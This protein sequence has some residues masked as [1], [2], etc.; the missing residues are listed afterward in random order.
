MIDLRGYTFDEAKDVLNQMHLGIQP[1]GEE[2]SEEYPEGQI[3]SQSEEK[4]TMVEKNTTILVVISSGPGE[5]DVPDVKG[6]AKGDAETTLRNAGLVPVFD[7]ESSDSIPNDQVISQSPEAG[8]KAKKGDTVTVML[9]KGRETVRMPD[10][11]NKPEAEAREE[12]KNLG[13]TVASTSSDYSDEIPE[14]NVMG[15]SIAPDKMVEQ[16]TQVTLT[17]SLGRK[18]TTQYYSL[19]N[20]NIDLPRSIPEDAIRVE[21]KSP[22]INQKEM[23]PSIPGLQPPSP[24]Q[25]MRPILKTAARDI[26]SL[27]GNGLIGTRMTQRLQK[28]IRLPL[29]ALD[30]RRINTGSIRC[31]ER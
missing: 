13:L 14:G 6:K 22:S 29:T 4:G 21:A 28:P 12:I 8:E 26:L 7:Y 9:S 2:S 20:Y 23:T 24:L 31:R 30:L 11:W 17:I 15:Q 1:N 5:F 25:S 3:V 18:I 10:V 19:N 27:T 16:G